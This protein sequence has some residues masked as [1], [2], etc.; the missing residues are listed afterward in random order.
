MNEIDINKKSS[1]DVNSD[2]F[3]L[4]SLGNSSKNYWKKSKLVDS[5]TISRKARSTTI[6][7]SFML[8]KLRHKNL[9]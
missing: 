5:N 6:T 7:L 8:P 9:L 2:K 3:I 1:E 4:F